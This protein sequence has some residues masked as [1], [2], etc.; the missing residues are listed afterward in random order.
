MLLLIASNFL[1][2]L[3]NLINS[4]TFILNL[5]LC[6]YTSFSDCNYIALLKKLAAVATE[7]ASFE[8]SMIWNK[9]WLLAE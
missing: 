8:I 1:F 4:E 3:K 2:A 9:F 5:S 6:L 7:E